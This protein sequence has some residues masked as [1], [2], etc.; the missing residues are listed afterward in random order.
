MVKLRYARDLILVR[1]YKGRLPPKPFS[2]N[3]FLI[4]VLEICVAAPDGLIKKSI[5]REVVRR[6]RRI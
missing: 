5:S 3:L 1:T 6:R 2:C 4:A